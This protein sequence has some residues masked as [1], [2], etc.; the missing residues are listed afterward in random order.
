M[1]ES[2]TVMYENGV[3]RPLTPLRLRERQT[4]RIQILDITPSLDKS[5]IA[6]QNLAA[7]NILTLPAGYSDVPSPSESERCMLADKLGNI[8]GKPLSEIILEERGEL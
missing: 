6:L 8:P 1:A 2:I 3:L 5:E 4:I 7:E